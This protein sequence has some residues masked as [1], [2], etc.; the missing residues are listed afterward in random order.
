MH[1]LVNLN[2]VPH[3][4]VGFDRRVKDVEKYVYNPIEEFCNINAD[5]E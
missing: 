3:T 2:K 1:T 4:L 5:K